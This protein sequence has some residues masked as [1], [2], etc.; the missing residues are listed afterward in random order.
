MYYCFSMPPKG[1]PGKRRAQN[2]ASPGRAKRRSRA[3]A[4]FAEPVATGERR[5]S[6]APAR[7]VTTTKQVVPPSR[8]PSSDMRSLFREVASEVIVEMKASVAT[9]VREQVQ[10]QVQVQ[11][12]SS[13]APASQVQ[14]AAQPEV[15]AE[16]LDASDDDSSPS[17][18]LESSDLI[19]N[20]IRG[21]TTGEGT[22]HT[23]ATPLFISNTGM[24]GASV[25]EKTK[26]RICNDEFIDLEL[27]IPG[28]DNDFSINLESRAGETSKVSVSHNRAKGFRSVDEWEEA[29]LIY[30]SIYMASHPH[31]GVGL[32]KHLSLVR[33]LARQ[34]HLWRLYDIEFRRLRAVEKFS[35]S[36]Y[37]HELFDRS[38]E[39]GPGFNVPITKNKSP[40]RNSNQSQRGN[41]NSTPSGFCFLFARGDKCKSGTSCKYHHKCFHCSG[42]HSASKCPKPGS[43]SNKSSSI[44]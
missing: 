38:K 44:G 14:V 11:A 9:M 23:P 6:R 17:E 12:N 1:K 16:S 15:M 37:H 33:R 36:T 29:F 18:A 32:L 31:E 5:S 30:A 7:P 8:A 13:T 25:M 22:P 24:L 27:L 43:L 3:P 34:G 39:R 21:L 4:R 28:R 42:S 26:K 35:F 40:F 19:A 41:R 20:A 2:G 10:E